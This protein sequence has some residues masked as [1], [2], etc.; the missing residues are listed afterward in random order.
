VTP[1]L[2]S[3]ILVVYPKEITSLCGSV[4]CLCMTIV[5]FFTIERQENNLNTS[6]CAN[7]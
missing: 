4:I 3:A 6:C 1:Q 7:G 2:P 5:A